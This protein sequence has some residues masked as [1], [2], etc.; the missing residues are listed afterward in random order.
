MDYTKD[1]ITV[2]YCTD[3][4]SVC[5][6]INNNGDI[7]IDNEIL[8]GNYNDLINRLNHDYNIRG[9][10]KRFH[11]FLKKSWVSNDDYKTHSFDIVK[12]KYSRNNDYNFNNYLDTLKQVIPVWIKM[13]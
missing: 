10:S 12:G 9:K 13:L 2:Q 11:I 4:F 8:D 5:Y 1:Y 7:Y 6:R 3:E